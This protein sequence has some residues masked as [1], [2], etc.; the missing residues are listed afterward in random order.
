MSAPESLK[1]VYADELK[2]LWSANDQMRRALETIAGKVYDGELKSNF[3]S[4]ITGIQKHSDRLKSLLQEAGEEAEPEHCRG[5]EGLVREALK[6]TT[7]EAPGDGELFDLVAVSQYQRMCHYGIAGFGTA[8]TYAR[9]LG[10]TEQS[11]ALKAMVSDIYK[12]DEYA[13]RLAQGSVRAAAA[14]A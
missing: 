12:A 14:A 6:H 7:Q 13:T 11:D 3:Q 8:A 10:M 9:A 5:M 4:S 1:D 2:D